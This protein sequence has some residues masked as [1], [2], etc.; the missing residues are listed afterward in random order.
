MRDG[1]GCGAGLEARRGVRKL[2]LWIHQSGAVPE[3]SDR[4]T[5]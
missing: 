1:M 3:T 5:C 2:W 4:D